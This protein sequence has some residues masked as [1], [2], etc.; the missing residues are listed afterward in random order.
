MTARIHSLERRVP[1]SM[2]VAVEEQSG[3]E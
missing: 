2:F 1:A 3:D